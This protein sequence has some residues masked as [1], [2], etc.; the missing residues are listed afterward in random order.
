MALHRLYGY[1]TFI[2]TGMSDCMGMSALCCSEAAMFWDNAYLY[3]C[4]SITARKTGP[5]PQQEKEKESKAACL[6]LSMGSESVGRGGPGR[7]GSPLGVNYTHC[8]VTCISSKLPLMWTESCT[9]AIN[10]DKRGAWLSRYWCPWGIVGKR[11]EQKHW[12][13]WLILTLTR[14]GGYI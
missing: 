8:R 10:Y 2:Q 5:W 13:R 14:I 9:R 4:W 1:T 11:R 6:L 12:T 7:V 3:C